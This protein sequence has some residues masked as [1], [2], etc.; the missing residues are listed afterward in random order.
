M[1][2]PHRD[3][4]VQADPEGDRTFGVNVWKLLGW[5]EGGSVVKA[6]D[7]PKEEAPEK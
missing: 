4:W 1:K 3:R 7:L 5:A 6:G 2:L